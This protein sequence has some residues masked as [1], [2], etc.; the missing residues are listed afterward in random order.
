MKHQILVIAAGLLLIALSSGCVSNVPNQTNA[1]NQ[2]GNNSTSLVSSFDDCTK[3][4]TIL[5]SYPRQCSFN[6]STFTEENC[7]DAQ[8]NVLTLSDAIEI[9]KEGECG[10]NLTSACACP[11]NYILQGNVCNPSCYY[12]NPPCEA[13]SI[14]CEK[15]YLCNNATGTYWIN[16][17][18]TKQG[19]SPAC[20]ITIANYSVEINWRCTGFNP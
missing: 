19:C 3:V 20:V 15:P 18:V 16:M 8:G 12:S 6:G 7:N 17:N 9:A 5:E 13:P 11:E 4:G 14:L 1:Q 10:N 2:S